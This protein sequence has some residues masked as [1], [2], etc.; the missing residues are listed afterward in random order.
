M[1]IRLPEIEELTEEQIKILDIEEPIA[2]YGGAGTGKTILS[3]WKHILNWKERDIKS[4][5][6][7]YTH[8]LTRYF[9]LSIAK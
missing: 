4:F 9:E 3:I 7:T 1:N 5:L 6:I 2:I 8:T